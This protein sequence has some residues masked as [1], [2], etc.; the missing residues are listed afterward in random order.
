[1]SPRKGAGLLVL[2]LALACGAAT[3][4]VAQHDHIA[5]WSTEPGGGALT[6]EYDFD[7]RKVRVFQSFCTAG[8]GPCLFTSVDPAFLAPTE[9]DEGDEF[10]PIRDGTRISLEI[11]AIDA[12]LT[13]SVSGNRLDAPG[14]TAALG[15]M[16]DI[17]NHPSWQLLVP[18]G[19]IGDYAVSFKLTTTSPLYA[20]SEPFTTIVTNDV[21]TPAPTPTATPSPTPIPC[22]G[23]CNS[24]RVVTID[25]LVQAINE[26]LGRQ[27]L[28]CS[29]L[30]ADGDGV[31]TVGE[32]IAAV[33]MA[34]GG[35]P[36]EPT[37][38][39]VDFQ[40]IQDEIFTPSCLGSGCH[41]ARDRAQNLVLEEGE[42]RG[43]LVGV[44]PLNFAA[45]SAGLMLVDPG[46]PET[47]FLLVKL[48]NPRPDFGS[49]MPLDLPPLSGADIEMVRNWIAA[50]APE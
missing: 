50:G 44:R 22:P 11:V 8:D 42:A 35:C 32:V 39:P 7:N 45:A 46:R 23:D 20:E 16:P 6:A 31:V 12:A 4:A 34:L 21:P 43:N 9:D 15:I 30:D 1:V 47:S 41:N 49:R 19:E 29:G 10:H 2:S 3:P 25:E 26:A 14:K 33:G 24:D 27:P 37:P 5:L 38:A 18:K 36:A 40:R 17:H 48:G 28:T 13:L